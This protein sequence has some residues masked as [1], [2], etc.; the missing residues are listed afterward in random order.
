MV[1]YG[2][3]EEEYMLTKCLPMDDIQYY[4]I[5]KIRVYLCATEYLDRDCKF[6]SIFYGK[7]KR[8]I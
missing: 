6:L 8:E 5:T 1:L 7:T 3:L 4:E 2:D